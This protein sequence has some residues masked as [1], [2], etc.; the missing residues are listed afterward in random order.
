[1]STGSASG[2]VMNTAAS[3]VTCRG[4][5]QLALTVHIDYSYASATDALTDSQNATWHRAG[6]S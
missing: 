6:R 2:T 5:T 3:S 1:M 4:A